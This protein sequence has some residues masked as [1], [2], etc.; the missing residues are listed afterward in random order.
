MAKDLYHQVVKEAL[1]NE[2]W[3]VTHDPYKLAEWDPDW[4]IDLGAERLFA[5][6]KDAQRIAV[7]VKSFWKS[8]LLMSS[9]EHWA[10]TSIIGAV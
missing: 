4:A 3:T 1:E 8:R 10:N 7:E 6:Q 5:A 9:I 2:G